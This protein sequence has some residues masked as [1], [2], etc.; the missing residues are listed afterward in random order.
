MKDSA[1][2]RIAPLLRVLSDSTR[3]SS[4]R[5]MSSHYDGIFPNGWLVLQ[6][7]SW[8]LA[9]VARWIEGQPANQGVT[10][11]GTCL[12]CGPGPLLGARER[13]PHIDVSLPLF[14]CPFPSV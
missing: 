4:A 14:L 11:Q 5:E 7:I 9:G 12:G 3:S 1:S 13:Q 2:L 8:V 6:D 10:S